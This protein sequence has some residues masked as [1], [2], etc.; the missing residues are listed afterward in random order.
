MTT[1]TP[2]QVV[3]VPGDFSGSSLQPKP[4]DQETTQKLAQKLKGI[5]QAK[6][7]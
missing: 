4:A 3:I 1:S 7:Q 6:A 2:A 5:I